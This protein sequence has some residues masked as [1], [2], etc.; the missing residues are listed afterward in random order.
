MV[1]TGIMGMKMVCMVTLLSLVLLEVFVGGISIFGLDYT[2]ALLLTGLACVKALKQ[3][4]AHFI[5]TREV[6]QPISQA[7]V[8]KL[9]LSTKPHYW[10]ASWTKHPQH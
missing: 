7:G 8:F 4:L 2:N 5:W 10:C 3:Q 6:L 1:W 9:M